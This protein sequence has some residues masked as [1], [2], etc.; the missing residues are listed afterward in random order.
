MEDQTDNSQKPKGKISAGIMGLA[1]TKATIISKI[2][3]KKLIPFFILILILIVILLP[4][5]YKIKEKKEALILSQSKEPIQ[6]A[7]D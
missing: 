4:L 6:R 7:G 1:R 2:K 5:S 3:F